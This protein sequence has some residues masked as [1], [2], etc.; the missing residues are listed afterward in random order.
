MT[1]APSRK[2]AVILHADVVD[3]TAIVRLNETLAHQRIQDTFRRFS[4][5]ID[6]CGGVAR[7]IRGD[8]LV[9]EFP[10]ASDAV[11]AAID[12]QTLN[13]RYAQS[14]TDEIQPIL[15]VGIGMGE[16]VVADNTITG[17]GVVLAQ[18]IEQLAKPGGVCLQGAVYET[19]PKRLPFSY[20][21]LGEQ[22]LKGFG[23]PVRVYVATSNHADLKVPDSVAS[24]HTDKAHKGSG[25]K[26]S[27]VVLPFVNMSNDPEQDCF[28]DG[29]TEDVI[30]ELSRYRGIVVT[31]VG[32][33][34]DLK[35]KTDDAVSIASQVGAQHALQGSARKAGDKLRVTVQLIDGA[36]SAR[37]W[38]EKYD[39]FVSDSFA[40]QDD[41]T[42][43]IVAR[44]ADH[45]ED[46]SRQAVLRKPVT[47]LTAYE[48]VL[49]AKGKFSNFG[50][51]QEDILASR[52]LYRKAIEQDPGCSRAYAGLAET[53][54]SEVTSSWTT[55]R[56]LAG[57]QA[58]E[59]ARKAL[60]IDPLDSNARGT[61]ANTY[62]HLDQNYD[63]ANTELGKAIAL[64]P[65]D[66]WNLCAAS[67]ICVTDGKLDEA[68]EWGN[69]AMRRNP[70]HPDNCLMVMG[71]A[72]YLAGRY[73]SAIERFRS[74]DHPY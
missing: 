36:S 41:V 28:C 29:L 2:L 13:G 25:S 44:V 39:R 68:I 21:S 40:V 4:E 6:H 51:S 74:L 47:D 71:L 16:V 62:K 63:R 1:D 9:A 34:L 17:D 61:L 37:L 7:E 59:Y 32:S 26:P 72:D 23:D 64:N 53:F 35:D 69:E 49:R 15:R 58:I 30:T 20:N 57:S 66:Y 38:A 11:E 65:N 8:A 60:T 3:S 12:F 31:A 24:I 22:E 14:L 19:V 33:S 67:G 55:D 45:L 48:L 73:E 54:Q 10:R 5:V 43:S 27:I 52:D 56:E 70:L 46:T 42:I 18:R 50:G